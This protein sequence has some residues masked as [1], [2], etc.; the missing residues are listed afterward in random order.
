V[1]RPAYSMVGEFAAVL[2]GH[3]LIDVPAGTGAS[4][5]LIRNPSSLVELSS[6]V[7]RRL[8]SESCEIETDEG[9]LGI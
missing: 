7:M 5:L 1:V 6:H 4:F 2:Y 3:A 9:A 8:V